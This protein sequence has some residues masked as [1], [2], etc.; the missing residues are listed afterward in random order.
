MGRGLYSRKHRKD[1]GSFSATLKPPETD[2]GEEKSEQRK[3]NEALTS[4]E[5]VTFVQSCKFFINTNK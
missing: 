1:P 3:R 4:I 2:P 5:H